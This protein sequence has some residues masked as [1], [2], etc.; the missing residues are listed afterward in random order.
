MPWKL[1]DPVKAEEWAPR[2]EFQ[3]EPKPGFYLTEDPPEDPLQT[4][5]LANIKDLEEPSTY[6]C[7]AQHSQYED[8][9]KVDHYEDSY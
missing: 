4:C 9:D 7:T 8:E 6:V 2:T 5:W 1:G 3:Y